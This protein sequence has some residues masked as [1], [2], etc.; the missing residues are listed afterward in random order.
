MTRA[1]TGTR[2]ICL[3]LFVLLG[4]SVVSVFASRDDA[5][6]AVPYEDHSLMRVAPMTGDQLREFRL[7][8]FDIAQELPDGSFEVVA[9]AAEREVL[10][11]N[12]AAEVEIE[13][14]EEHYQKSLSTTS[15]MGEYHSFSETYQELFWADL[16]YSDLADLD[17]IGY[18]LEGNPIWAIKISDNVHVDED[19]PEI[20]F[21]GLIHARE[22][23]GLETV[24]Y[25]MDYLLGNYSDPEVAQFVDNT[26]IYIV[27]IVNP[28]GYLYNEM[29]NPFGG[30]MWRKNRRDNGDG[31]FGVDLNR[32]WGYNWAWDD[33]TS[34]PRPETQTYRGTGP[35]SEPETQVMRDWINTRDF[36][37]IINYHAFGG[38]T[39]AA[40]GFD[41]GIP[42]PDWLIHRAMQDSVFNMNGYFQALGGHN[43]SAL[44]W[45]YGE[46]FT[47]KKAF[48]LLPE[49]GPDFWPPEGDIYELV[50][51]NH[52]VNLYYIREAQRLAYRPTR[53]L[54][55]ELDYHGDTTGVCTPDYSVPVSF[56]NVDDLASLSVEYW[57]EL[58]GAT[59]EQW[60]TMTGGTVVLDPG[61]QLDVTVDISP[62]AAAGLPIGEEYFLAG[63]MLLVVEK[64]T[65]PLVTDTLG[66]PVFTF[67]NTIDSDGD[68]LTD[69]CDNCPDSA[70]PLQED[71]DE[72]G[73]GDVCDDDIDGDDV[74]NESDN[75]LL[76]F[77]P[78][79][80]D[81]NSDGIGDDCDCYCGMWGD[82]NDDE[83][84]DPLD[85]TF[86]V[87]YVY[88]SL[89]G[90]T[91]LPDCPYGTGDVDC[92]NAVDPVDVAYYV[93]YVYLSQDAF[94]ADPCGE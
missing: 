42:N 73:I 34:S 29:T 72:D 70:N 18:S 5:R 8:H 59:P 67:F 90:R 83:G 36:S 26:E 82:V 86:M 66:Y 19:E 16:I 64:T 41:G 37:V 62:Q 21:N 11:S 52:E 35:F 92:N 38:Y 17:T 4:S 45:Q 87:N 22:P 10:I 48:V 53:S 40:W 25:L 43:G 89:D 32:N 33:F 57:F 24:I 49:V 39:V 71:M 9:T 7:Q 55:T 68:E 85:V 80:A 28:D 46:Q 58:Y 93:N 88:L 60:G 14:M 76:V 47:K 77:N 75:C 81:S 1:V 44:D 3:L 6:G 61:E 54:G 74:P 69:L 31:S 56:H 23:I 12:Y 13:N 30:G 51:E 78:E 20:M 65:D 79:Q 15:E 94:C 84:I 27:P 50:M 2:V 91:P 63:M